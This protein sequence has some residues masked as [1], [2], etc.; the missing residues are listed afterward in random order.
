MYITTPTRVEFGDQGEGSEIIQ[1]AA[2]DWHSA[3]LTGTTLSG[4]DTS[5]VT[6]FP[7]FF[8]GPRDTCAIGVRIV[9]PCVCLFRISTVDGRVFTWGH[10]LD[11]QL[12]Y[13]EDVP[14]DHASFEPRVVPFLESKEIVIT[15]I[16]CGTWHTVAL[17]GLSSTLGSA[18]LFVHL[19]FPT[20]RV[21]LPSC[22]FL[23]FACSSVSLAHSSTGYCV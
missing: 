5:T 8:F 19:Y 17:S 13:G 2:G 14:M 6:D 23:P 12:G 21:A 7:L 11:G 10:G 3:A 9:M 18:E 16:R 1:I 22:P 20:H 15:T 4:P